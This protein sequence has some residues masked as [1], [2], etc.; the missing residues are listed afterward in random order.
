MLSSLA[1]GVRGENLTTS[2]ELLLD[3]VMSLQ[4]YCSQPFS[5][6]R[7]NYLQSEGAGGEKKIY[8]CFKQLLAQLLFSLLLHAFTDLNLVP[9]G[10]KTK[11]QGKYY[12]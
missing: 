10:L 4:E 7:G 3:S 9:Q 5:H 11:L 8:T 1:A 12:G 2:S 6:H